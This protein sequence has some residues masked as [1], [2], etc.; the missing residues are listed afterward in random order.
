MSEG[1]GSS[2]GRGPNPYISFCTARRP[3]VKAANPGAAP[4]E[5][6]SLLAA[7]WRGLSEQQKA[8]YAAGA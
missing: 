7:E 6:V 5:I 1:S 2:T 3:A 8:G 4:S